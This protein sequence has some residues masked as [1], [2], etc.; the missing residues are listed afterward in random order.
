VSEPVSFTVGDG[1]LIE[2]F[3]KAIFGLKAGDKRSIF[4]QAKNAFGEWQ[5]GN[6][7]TFDRNL[8]AYQLK[9]RFSGIFCR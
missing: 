1:N 6:V 5:E 4:I 8:F 7:Q 9:C 3:E 2:G